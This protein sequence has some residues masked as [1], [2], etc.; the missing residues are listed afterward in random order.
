MTSVIYPVDKRKYFYNIKFLHM[1]IVFFSMDGSE[2]DELQGFVRKKLL[3]LQERDSNISGA[4]VYF[5]RQPGNEAGDKVCEIKLSISGSPIP[6]RRNAYSY[7]QAA[8]DVITE[9]TRVVAGQGEESI[10]C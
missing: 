5:R 7:D 3:A 8:G 4:Q 2:N 10:N 1:N 6:V 9:L